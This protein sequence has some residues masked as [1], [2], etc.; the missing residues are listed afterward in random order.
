VHTPIEEGTGGY[1]REFDYA[2]GCLLGKVVVYLMLNAEYWLLTSRRIESVTGGL[3]VKEKITVVDHTTYTPYSL[4]RTLFK[5]ASIAASTTAL[6][7]CS[8][9]GRSPKVRATASLP[10]RALTTA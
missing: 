2:L 3:G 5:P 9:V 10:L 6:E 4:G 8:R 7:F 1:G